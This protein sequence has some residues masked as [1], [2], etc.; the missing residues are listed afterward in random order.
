M[1]NETSAGVG[2]NQLST[3]SS[4]ALR[5]TWLLWAA[6]ASQ[7][8][9]ARP[10][11]GV[12]GSPLTAL[13]RTVKQQKSVVQYRVHNDLNSEVMRNV[14]NYCATHSFIGRSQ[15]NITTSE[16]YSMSVCLL[17]RGNL[18]TLRHDFI[19]AATSSSVSSL[20]AMSSTT[21]SISEFGVTLTCRPSVNITEEKLNHEHLSAVSWTSLLTTLC[22]FKM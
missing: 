19:T 2:V 4:L 17:Q 22:I 1:E 3:F 16:S 20:R 10:A 6:A 8:C 15:I 11:G 5:L 13:L 7:V 21:P 14:M 12:S 9:P 18:L